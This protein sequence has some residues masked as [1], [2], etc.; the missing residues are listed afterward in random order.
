[1]AYLKIWRKHQH[2]VLILAEANSCDKNEAKVLVG[3]SVAPS[4][5]EKG[6]TD[7]SFPVDVRDYIN[8]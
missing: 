5:H 1:M 3:A 6:D 2:E 4:V 7:S 8:T